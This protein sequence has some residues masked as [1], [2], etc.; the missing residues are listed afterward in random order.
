MSA[1]AATGMTQPQ[2]PTVRK[3]AGFSDVGVT[4]VQLALADVGEAP[5]HEVAGCGARHCSG[6]YGDLTR[7]L[8]PIAGSMRCEVAIA[9]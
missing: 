3:G 5:R 2:F 4:R 8:V 9:G 6:F 1:V 7:A